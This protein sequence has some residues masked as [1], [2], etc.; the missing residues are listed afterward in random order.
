ML[1]NTI[2]P[3]DTSNPTPLAALC[4]PQG[5]HRAIRLRKLSATG[6]MAESEAVPQLW[7]PI[8]VSLRNVGKVPG[9]V[10]WVE[11]NRFGVCFDENIDPSRVDY[12]L[13]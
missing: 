11:G 3:V 1:A 13:N 8:Q 10:S 9:F 2:R 7:T 5:A 6:L 12:T 4:L